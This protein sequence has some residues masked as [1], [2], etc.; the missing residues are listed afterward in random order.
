MDESYVAFFRFQVNVGDVLE[1][2]CRTLYASG[3]NTG[4]NPSKWHKTQ[5]EEEKANPE[6]GIEISNL[7]LKS[8]S[9]REIDRVSVS[10][11]LEK[12]TETDLN[13]NIE[14]KKNIGYCKLPSV[15]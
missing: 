2:K 13:L 14:G 7:G 4:T 10:F 12:L 9:F 1:L 15:T 3:E 5:K 6:G 8:E 11:V